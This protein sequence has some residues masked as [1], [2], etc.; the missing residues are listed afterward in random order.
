MLG[1]DD[2]RP[3]RTIEGDS[4]QCPVR[5]CPTCVPMQRRTFRRTPEFLCAVHRVY[6]GR[7]TFEYASDLDNLLSHAPEDLRLLA[8]IR[9]FKRESRFARERSEDA[10][11]WNVF[12]HLETSGRLIPWLSAMVG[13]KASAAMVHYWSFEASSRDT[14][15]PLAEAR[16][17]FGEVEGRGSEPDLVITTGDT[18]I[19]VEAKLG[20][21]NDTRPS[22][23]DGAR[24]RYTGGGDGWYSSVVNSSFDTVAVEQRRYELL[25][26]WLLGSWAAARYGKRFVLLN[27][28]CEGFEED[29]PSFVATHFRQDPNRLVHRVTWESVYRGIEAAPPFAAAD[30][31][32]LQY[33][34]GKTLG[35]DGRGRLMRAFALD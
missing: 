11:T 35:Y 17:A 24:N 1:A 6:I 21:S 5:D 20:S 30:E 25:R 7:S 14:W 19:W 23:V 3:Q 9:P 31:A 13:A 26:L 27:L 28:V 10:L 12:R 32:L 34:R 8:A 33:W 29:V 15:R 22:D 4:L 16:L 18:H 2:L